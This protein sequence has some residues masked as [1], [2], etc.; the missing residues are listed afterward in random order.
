VSK[1]AELDTA[2]VLE[3]ALLQYMRIRSM[4]ETVSRMALGERRLRARYRGA[5]RI[6]SELRQRD[7]RSGETREIVRHV[8]IDLGVPEM[9]LTIESALNL[10]ASAYATLSAERAARPA[11]WVTSVA[12]LIALLV[13]V[14]PLQELPNSVPVANMDETWALAPFRFL[15]DQGFWGPWITMTCVLLLVLTL[16][17][18]GALWRLKLVRLPSFR[19]GFE[20][21]TEFTVDH[22]GYSPS[23]S[24]PPTTNLQATFRS[25]ADEGK[26]S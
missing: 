22:A 17:V 25:D 2:L 26:R 21:P 18:L 15:A 24:E 19:K 7:L 6:F 14:Q 11:W 10:S 8:L 3:Y 4:E 5:V 16:W 9:R 20:W 1:F 23:S 13:A 12:T